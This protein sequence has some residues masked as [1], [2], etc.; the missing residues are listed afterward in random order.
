MS[1]ILGVDTSLT[2]LGLVAMPLSWDLTFRRVRAIT[3]GYPLPKSASVLQQLR[4]VEALANDVCAYAQRVNAEHV[5]LEGQL[6]HGQA[7]NVPKLCELIGVVRHELLRQRGI[8]AELAPLNSV[9]KL[10]LGWLPPKD[11]KAAVVAALKGVGAVFDDGDQYDAF[12]LCNWKA[13]ELGAPCLT[14]LLGEK[15]VKAKKSRKR[16][17]KLQTASD[18]LLAAGGAP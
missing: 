2:G 13:H 9:R 3:L 6:A 10:L 5:V 7:F 12:A 1:V 17:P 15:P 18:L 11:R 4:R 14:G 16:A 8:A